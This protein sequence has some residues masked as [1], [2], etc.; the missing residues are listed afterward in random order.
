MYLTIGAKVNTNRSRRRRSPDRL[1]S[2]QSFSDASAE[3][4]PALRSSC[5]PM[6][7]CAISFLLPAT[8]RVCQPQYVRNRLGDLPKGQRGDITPA[9]LFSVLCLIRVH[10]YP[11]TGHVTSMNGP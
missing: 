8:V 2:F 6:R 1:Y 11:S 3:I 5:P 4:R 10:D 9:N 7:S